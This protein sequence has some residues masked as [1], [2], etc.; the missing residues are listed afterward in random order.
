M[1]VT[2]RQNIRTSYWQLWLEIAKRGLGN[3]PLVKTS[4]QQLSVNP[5]D[6]DCREIIYNRI[7]SEDVKDLLYPEPFRKSNPGYEAQISGK[8]SLGKVCHT[9]MPWGIHPGSLTEHMSISGRTGGG[10]TFLIKKI[11]KQ[12]MNE[13]TTII[14]PDRKQDFCD[15]ALKSELLYFLLEDFM[16]NWCAP[17]DGVPVELWFSVLAEILAISFELRIAAQGMIVDILKKLSKNKNGDYP[18]LQD[19][20]RQLYLIT[21]GGRGSEKESARRIAFRINWLVSTLGDACA[22]RQRSDWQK[23]INTSWALSLAGL[24]GSLQSLCITIYFAK[25]LFYRI[26]NNLRSDKLKT[27]IVLDEA[28]M[29]FP[30]T[31]TK[32]TSI[33]LDY[34]Q[35]ARAFGIGVIFASQSMN[36]ASEIFANTAIKVCVGGF[37][38]GSDYNEFGS[39]VGLNREKLEFMKTI[40]RPGSAVVKDIRYPHPFTVRI[41]KE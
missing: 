22:A 9:R 8:I 10:K 40:S 2:N 1:A 34:F 30:K 29:I 37:G 3:D 4:M 7:R 20:S 13:E 28:S 18:T 26:Y 17:P 14:I 23:L 16:D 21:Q 41:D 32:K 19:I 33:L 5:Y 11:I 31:A 25:V 35:Q 36:L 38:H 15:L 24:A 27:L 6:N 39:A 12:L